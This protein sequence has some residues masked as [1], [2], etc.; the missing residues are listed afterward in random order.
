M[1]TT[2]PTTRPQVHPDNE[3]LMTRLAQLQHLPIRRVQWNSLPTG[4]ALL[5]ELADCDAYEAACDLLH[6]QNDGG[7]LL[8]ALRDV[9]R[10][11][12]ASTRDERTVIE[13]TCWPHLTCW[14]PVTS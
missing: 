3:R 7:R 8:G 2:Q 10:V 5:V 13:H 6:V 1:T 11:Y 12:D 4:Q 9:H 14:K